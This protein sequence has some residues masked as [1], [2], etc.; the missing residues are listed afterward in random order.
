M[1]IHL[2]A[3]NELEV[4]YGLFQLTYW[5]TDTYNNVA[6]SKL[7]VQKCDCRPRTSR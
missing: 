3:S 4:T 1:G 2:I 5:C 7:A 6:I